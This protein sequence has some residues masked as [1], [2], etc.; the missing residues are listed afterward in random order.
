M[1]HA[2]DWM[3]IAG[4]AARERQSNCLWKRSLLLGQ[5]AFDRHRQL[6][7]F[8]HSATIFLQIAYSLESGRARAQVRA[9]H[10]ALEDKEKLAHPTRFERVTFAFGVLRI[11][12]IALRCMRFSSI[13]DAIL[14]IIGQVARTF[15]GHHFSAW[16]A[17]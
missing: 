6:P 3:S 12:L 4:S 10:T 11:S 5:R 1:P 8:L 7:S 13:D 9:H 2:K 17:L 14:L 16:A 15:C